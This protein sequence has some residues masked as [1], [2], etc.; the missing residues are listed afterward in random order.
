[1]MDKKRKCKKKICL[2]SSSGGHYEQL[3]MLKPLGEKHNIFWVT[4]K[5][6]YSGNADYYL[7]QTGTNEFLLVFLA[8]ML[9][10]SFKTIGI[11]IKEKPDVVVTTG[12]MI[13]LPIS[14]LAKLLRKKVIYIETFARIY[15]CTRAGKLMYKFADLFIYQW[16][17]LKK[18]YPKGV[19]G[20]S[21]Y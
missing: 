2:I 16:E 13:A 11:W 8:K 20:G 19:Y 14:F 7:L 5:A 17:P 12:T 3:Q 6:D 18:H 1:M 10:N 15:D 9:I 21:I 4:E